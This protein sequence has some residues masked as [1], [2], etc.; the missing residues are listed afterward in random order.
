MPKERLKA[1][2]SALCTEYLE[3]VRDLLEHPE[4]QSM[5]Q[6]AQHGR[7]DCLRH[8]LNVS[9]TGYRLCRFFGLDGRAAARGGLLHDFFLYD[10]H[11]GNPYKGLHAFTHPRVA[12]ENAARCFELSPRERD[13]INKH[14]WPLTLKLPRYPE[15]LVILLVDKFYCIAEAL[16]PLG[17]KTT[18]RVESL[19]SEKGLAR[20]PY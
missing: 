18:R 9:F 20:A 5:R 17:L 11:K 15:S 13:V 19:I 2:D 6:Y 10:W 1:S 3:T 16:A 12:A 4:V 14:M 7:V 8:C